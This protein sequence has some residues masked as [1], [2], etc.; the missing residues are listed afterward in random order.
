MRCL[1]CGA[2]D[3]NCGAAALEKP[4]FGEDAK[5]IP[6]TPQPKPETPKPDSA[7]VQVDD[8]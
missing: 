3:A 6:V 1:I 8:Q 5:A 7:D 4:V 2:A